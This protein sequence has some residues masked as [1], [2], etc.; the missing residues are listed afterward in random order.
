MCCVLNM[1]VC[2]YTANESTFFFFV[3]IHLLGEEEEMT[4]A[5]AAATTARFPRMRLWPLVPHHPTS[6]ENEKMTSIGKEEEAGVVVEVVGAEE[7]DEAEGA[8]EGGAVAAVAAEDPFGIPFEGEGMSK[9][10]TIMAATI[11]IVL[12]IDDRLRVATT[13]VAIL[14]VALLAGAKMPSQVHQTKQ[15]AG[16]IVATKA[17]NCLR[18]HRNR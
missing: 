6:N 11:V 14:L 3:L 2:L 10:T 1:I 5:V 18:L 7:G 17:A 13:V 15:K 8:E 16:T 4:A 12:E 9:I